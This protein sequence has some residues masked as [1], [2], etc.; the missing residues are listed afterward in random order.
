[1]NALNTVLS[2]IVKIGGTAVILLGAFFWARAARE[3]ISTVRSF[4][5]LVF[6]FVFFGVMSL[7]E[8]PIGESIMIWLTV[9]YGVILAVYI[10]ARMVEHMEEIRAGEQGVSVN[11]TPSRKSVILDDI[12]S[13]ASVDS[14]GIDLEITSRG[15]LKRRKVIRLFGTVKTEEEKNKVTRIAERHTGE[16]YSVINNLS[17]R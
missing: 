6:T 9:V 12:G 16:D 5:A 8:P 7:R 3:N 14:S 11:P 2:W 4:M 1:M 17:L 13:D 10:V 15:L